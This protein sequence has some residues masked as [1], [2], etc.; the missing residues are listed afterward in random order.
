MLGFRSE[1]EKTVLETCDEA[2]ES[3]RQRPHYALTSYGTGNIG[4][5]MEWKVVSI[6]Q[7]G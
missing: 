6:V 7:N 3:P 4:R 1:E 5:D 2:F